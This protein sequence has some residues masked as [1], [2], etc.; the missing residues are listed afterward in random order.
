MSIPYQYNLHITYKLVTN[1]I[2][3]NVFDMAFTVLDDHVLHLVSCITRKVLEP[4]IA[5]YK[6]LIEDRMIMKLYIE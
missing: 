5:P 2:P 4:L 6:Y 3:W 1:N